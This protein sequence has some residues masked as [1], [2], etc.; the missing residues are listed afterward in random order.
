MYSKKVLRKMFNCLAQNLLPP[1]IAKSLRWNRLSPHPYSR[2]KGKNGIDKQMLEFIN[3]R[4]GFFVEI[5]AGDGVYLSNTYYFEKNLGWRG[6]LVDPVLHHHL[7][8]L[9]NRPRSISYL[10]AATNFEN[11]S[12]YITLKYGGYSTLAQGTQSDIIDVQEHL[13]D[14]ANYIP[15]RNAGVEFIAPLRTM[16]QILDSANAPKVID[17]FSLDVEG[18]ELEVLRGID[19][20]SYQIRWL[21]VESRD[22]DRISMY[23]APFGFSL[24]RELAGCDYL[25]EYSKKELI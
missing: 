7:S 13:V 14:A 3:Y 10:C 1:I 5:G 6:I 9:T 17:F 15:L 2:F 8:C 12:D 4:D 11:E 24:K 19:F 20:S 18:N 22:I 25:F 16:T 21:L 23:L